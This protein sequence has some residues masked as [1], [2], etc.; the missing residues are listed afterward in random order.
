MQGGQPYAALTCSPQ[1]A[2][3]GRPERRCASL[4]PAHAE[5]TTAPRPCQVAELDVSATPRRD[6]DV[7]GERN[8]VEPPERLRQ[9]ARDLIKFANDADA[10]TAT[11]DRLDTIVANIVGAARQL[12]GP[13]PRAARGEGG[14]QKILAYLQAHIGED[15]SGEELAAV[16]GIHEWARRL[17]ELRVEHGYDI[18]EV[19]DSVY[20]MHNATPD[21]ERARRW[22]SANTI[23]RQAG[24][25]SDRIKAFL[26]ESEGE[27]VNRDQ[28]DYVAKIKEGSRRVRELRDEEGWPINSH[29]DERGLRPG[30]YRLVSADPAD[31][32]DPRQRLYPERLRERVFERD[33]YTCQKCGRNRERALAAGDTRFYLEVHHKTAV[34][35]EL[36]ALPEDELN[37]EANLITLCHTDHLKETAAF[38]KRRRQERRGG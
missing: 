15:V 22:Q 24:S 6:F 21:T 35:E 3:R 32:R 11:R 13:R 33:N 25:A 30:E 1:E 27:I 36:D 5:R 31:R 34:A 26:T 29:I 4:H 7:A 16:S 38:Q 28:I 20:R 9:A 10:G 18:E 14:R 8:G 12:F 17:R 37:D 2:G 19:G 23:R